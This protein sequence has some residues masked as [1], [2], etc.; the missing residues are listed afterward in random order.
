MSNNTN[1]IYSIKFDKNMK[2]AKKEVK[3]SVSYKVSEFLKVVRTW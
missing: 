3:E 2:K 1:T